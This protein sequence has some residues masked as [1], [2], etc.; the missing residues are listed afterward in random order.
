MH[1]FIR[2]RLVRTGV[3]ASI[4]LASTAAVADPSPALDRV[5]LW[6]GGYY[7]NTD[8]T[9]DAQSHQAGVSSGRVDLAQ[10]HETIGRARLDVL[11]WDTQGLTFDYYSL[12]HTST[13]NLTHAFD[14]ADIPFELNTT[15]TG[16]LDFAAASLAYH[17][18]FGSGNDVF[19]VGLGA[20]HY[21]AKLGVSGT[22][23]LAELEAHVSAE[24]EQ[25]AVAPLLTLAWKHAF[26]DNLRSY[27]NVSGVKKNGGKLSG[28]IYDA[29]VGVE[30]FPWQNVGLGAEYG[31]AR[32]KLNRVT[33]SY[34]TDLDINLDGPAVFARFRF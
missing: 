18:W 7:T 32:V 20:T 26:S 29:R 9:I 3:F 15:V 16:K 28:H 13:Q 25:S 21:R 22:A 34:G 5:S 11:F 31:A 1:H 33:S 17:W 8:V 10:G 24:W 2:S 19:G 27:V 4:A 14:Y 12:G 23:T 30:W 6:L